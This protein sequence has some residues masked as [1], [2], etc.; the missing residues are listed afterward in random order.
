MNFFFGINNNYFKSEIQIPLFQNRNFRKQNLKLFKVYPKN[1]KWILKEIVNKKINN[2]FCILKNQD[3]SSN[4]IFFLTQ[5][6]IFDKFD[7]DKLKNFDTFTETYPEFRAN[8][9]LYLNNGGF[10]S[11]QSEYPYGMI[12]KKGSILSS[13]S[14]LANSEAEENYILIRNIY[15]KPIEDNFGVYLLNIVTK[16]VEQKFEVKTN[17]TNC[18]KIE[19]KYIKP[20]I[21]LTTDK[22]LCIPM[23]VSIKNNFLSFEHTHPPHEYILS[24]NKFKKV[25]DLKKE[26]NEIIN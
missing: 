5:N 16:K 8:L 1:N 15:E 13:V 19:K 11:Y 24:K 7:Q 21:F 6:E 10:S 23:Y 3:I 14:A 20:E 2:Y 9:K 22:Y 17:Y 4:D 25:S 12:T 18:I 26:I